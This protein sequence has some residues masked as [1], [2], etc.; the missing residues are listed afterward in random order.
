MTFQPSSSIMSK[1]EKSKRYKV[2]QISRRGFIYGSTA[3]SVTARP[4]FAQAQRHSGNDLLLV[5]TQTAGTSKG[6][7]AY[8]FDP[9]AGDLKQIGLAAEANNP[10]FLALSPRGDM[11]FVANELDHYEG[12]GGGAVSSYALN[13]KDARLVKI[14]E[15][16]SLGG[17]T[18]HVAVDPTGQS[19]FAANYGGGSAASFSVSNDGHLSPAVSFEQYTGHGPNP[20]RQQA[21]HAHRV[22]VSPNNRFLL[23]NDLG[24]DEIHIYHL[25]AAT[26]KLTPNDP[27]AWKSAPGSGPRAL[28]F[29]PRGKW[30]Y[31]VT[32]MASTVEV[33]RWDDH[34]GTLETIQQVSLKPEGYQGITAGCDIVFDHRARF[35]YV[36][37]RFDDIIVT[38]AVSPTDGKLTLLHRISCGGKVPRHLALDPTGRWLLVANQ[39]SDNIS[40]LARDPSSGLLTDSSKSFPLSKPQ[41]LVFA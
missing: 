37:D 8:T 22:T 16:A 40:V 11:V 41:C 31:C 1:R 13:K 19:V 32:E 24:L 21:P 28:R 29:H 4:W 36:A 18:C 23:V 33:L 12:K 2:Q 14:D 39:A 17:G 38:F 5:G 26:A 25:D 9:A 34:R 27:P 30:A 35:A 10:T 3:L 15:V 6:I 7:Y 20:D